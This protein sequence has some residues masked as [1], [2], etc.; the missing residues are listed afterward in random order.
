MR[1]SLYRSRE[2]LGAQGFSEDEREV[3][4]IVEAPRVRPGYDDNRN[5]ARR[6][7]SAQLT[8]HIVT[9]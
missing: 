3:P 7:M 8:K 6:R 2:R 4:R 1:R 9:M 5:M